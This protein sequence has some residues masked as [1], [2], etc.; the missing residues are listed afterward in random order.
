MFSSASLDF[1]FLE[2]NH[3]SIWC[4]LLPAKGGNPCFYHGGQQHGRFETSP[5]LGACVFSLSEEE[6]WVWKGDRMPAEPR[7]CGLNTETLIF[8]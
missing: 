8:N 4:H 6:L 1:Q 2:A 7:C 5:R 3:K